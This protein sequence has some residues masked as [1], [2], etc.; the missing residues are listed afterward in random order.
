MIAMI[1]AAGRGER[2]RPITDTIPK[3]LMK[4]KGE[5][6]IDRH[7]QMLSACG[8]K[9]VVINLGWLGNKIADHVGSG[10]RFGLQVIYSDEYENVL[11]TGGGICKALPLLGFEPFWVI[12]ADTY[13]EFQLP[14]KDLR[15]NLSGELVV[16]PNPSYK[17]VGDFDLIEG[18]ICNSLAPAYTFSGIARYHPEFFYGYKAERFSIVPLI[19]KAADSGKIGGLIFEKSW[20]DVGTPERLREINLK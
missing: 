20:H 16:V 9:I 10:K 19:R 5:I 1:L 14:R 18:K 15:R 4:V 11:D 3:A 13:T 7:L 12:N 17:E 8:I 2:L 6:L